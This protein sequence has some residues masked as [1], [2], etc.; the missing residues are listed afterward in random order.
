M[1]SGVK[2]SVT[3]C[4][5]MASQMF[6][7]TT[8]RVTMS[9]TMGSLDS[10]SRCII[11]CGKSKAINV[12]HTHLST[13]YYNSQMILQGDMTPMCHFCD[14]RHHV[15][16]RT[17]QNVILTSSTLSGLQYSVDWTWAGKVPTHCDM[18]AIPGGKIITLKRAWERAYLSN[19]LPI[20]TVLV[21]GLEDI[22]DL[23]KLYQD[24]HTMAQMAELISE[25]VLNAIEA[26]HRVIRD[27]SEK[28]DVNDTLAVGTI[29]HV[30]AMYWRET[31]GEYPTID[32]QN[33]KE[34]VDRTN[35]KIQ[36]FNLKNGRRAAP[37]LQQGGDRGKPN[38]RVYMWNCWVGDKKEDMMDLKDPQRCGLARVIVKY[39]EKGTPLSVQHLD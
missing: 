21:A 14:I 3:L 26:L 18:E 11:C 29:V 7:S 9:P 16:H 23:A 1:I 30:P 28:Y 5:K 38:K 20:D 15:D 25:D 12:Q 19:P 4:R 31:D 13:R 33:L 36:A 35:L 34:V 39:F 24:K 6:L 17:R 2:C 27:H 37:R 10:N 22:R 8:S 32:Y